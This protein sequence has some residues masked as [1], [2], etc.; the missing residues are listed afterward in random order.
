V[1]A[2][3]GKARRLEQEHLAA[4]TLQA[5]LLPATL[6][7][8]TGLTIAV[9]YLPASSGAEVG[10]DWYDVVSLP[11]GH[12]G[13]AVGDVAGHDI[14]AAAAMGALRSAAR[15]LIGHSR[16][17]AELLSLLQHSWDHLGI[18][19]MATCMVA[20]LDPTT[21]HL[22]LASAGHPPPLTVGPDGAGYLQ[23]DPSPPLGSP[24]AAVSEHSFQ[25]T[26]G[27]VLL[28]YTD[29]LIERRSAPLGPGMDRLLEVAAG[30]PRDPESL[31]DRLLDEL[32]RD[33]NDDVALLAVRFDGDQRTAG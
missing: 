25:L 30:A 19:H 20:W 4:H 14:G 9:R 8:I 7:A 18:A 29:G 6:P 23:V 15:A 17:P 26:P 27:T 33:R 22:R 2:V 32:G 10:G 12:A 5:S 13:L 28:F 21:G 24:P 1:A 31:C 3:A 16:G 11:H